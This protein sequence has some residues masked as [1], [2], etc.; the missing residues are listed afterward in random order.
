MHKFRTALFMPGS[1]P[2]FL[3]NGGNYGA[4]A[5]IMDIEDAVTPLEKDAARNLVRHALT[6]FE[7]P[8]IRMVRIN[9]IS[10]TYWKDDLEAIVPGRPDAI[11]L[12]KC[13]KASD[14]ERFDEYVTALESENGIE[15]GTIK[16]VCLLE[17]C[18][19]I[20]NGY[21]IATASKRNDSLALGAVDLT[22]DMGTELSDSGEE[23]QYAR[24]TLLID[25]K[26]AGLRAYD[27]SYPDVEN[28]PGL[29]KWTKYSKQ[30]GYDGRPVIS[31]AHIEI[32][33]EMIIDNIIFDNRVED[34][35]MG[36]LHSLNKSELD[37]IISNLDLSNN[38]TV[39]LKAEN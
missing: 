22:F 25:A 32:V 33:N 38:N 20:V 14:V 19:G 39:I 23:M 17:T 36:I 5:V 3:V 13:E 1:N 15:E 6:E 34:D 18:Q 9:D 11:W 26:A 2:S 28:I 29:I 16:F 12:P 24:A 21:Q 10:T 31:P 30:L 37:N 35:M 27:T 8:V 4:D 7:F